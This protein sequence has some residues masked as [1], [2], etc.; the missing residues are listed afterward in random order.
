MAWWSVKAQG[1]ICLNLLCPVVMETIGFIS[2]ISHISG[3]VNSLSDC[4][5]YSQANLVSLFV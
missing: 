3:S 1:Q 4:L 5:S 2:H